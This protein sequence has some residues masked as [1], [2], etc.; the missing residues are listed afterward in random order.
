MKFPVAAIAA[1]LLLA[2]GVATAFPIAVGAVTV[3]LLGVMAFP[4]AILAAGAVWCYKRKGRGA[5]PLLAALTLVCSGVFLLQDFAQDQSSK[6]ALFTNADTSFLSPDIPFPFMEARDQAISSQAVSPAEFMEGLTAGHFKA[7]KISTYPSLFMQ[8]GQVS[9]SEIWRDKDVLIK[10]VNDLGGRVVLVDQYGGIAGSVAVAALKNFGLNIGFLQGGTTALSSLGWSMV[11]QGIAIGG[12]TVPVAEYRS[13]ISAHPDA[14]VIGVTT[15]DEF[16]KDG[17]IFGNRTLSLGDFISNYRELTLALMGKNVFVVGFETN[18]T[19]AT[20]IIVDLLVKA[21]VEVHYVMPNPDE[22]LV[23]PA[24]F[25]DYPN[26]SRTVTIEDAERYVLSRPDVEF[27]DFSEHAWP[28]GLH[29]LKDRYHR[30]PMEEVA[31]GRLPDFIASLDPQKVYIGLAFDRRTAYHSLLAGEYL[32]SRGAPWLGRFTL[33]SSLTESFL[34]IEEL[35]TD[36]EQFAYLIRNAGG[37]IGNAILGHGMALTL[38]LGALL[39]STA[40]FVRRSR[41]IGNTVLAS[42]VVGVWASVIQARNDYPQLEYSYWAFQG[43]CS[44]ALTLVC[45]I[46]WWRAQPKIRSFSQYTPELPPK[47]ALLNL[48]QKRGHRVLSGFVVKPQD[49]PSLLGIRL[50]A[51]QYIVRSAMARE[52]LD[53]ESTAGLYESYICPASEV[54]DKASQVFST[55]TQA[56]IDGFALVQPYCNAAW[57]GVIQL[58]SNDK[59]PMVICDI[60]SAE[61]V[62]SGEGATHSFEFPIWDMKVAPR[63]IRSAALALQDLV[64]VGAISIEFA[65]SRTGQLTI[66]QVNLQKSRACAAMRLSHAARKKVLEVECAHPDAISAAIVSAMAPGH[67]IAYG[68]RRFAVVVSPR[69]SRLT[70]TQDLK[71]L[72]FDPRLVKS[73]HLLAWVDQYSRSRE[74]TA[75]CEA[76]VA[77]VAAALSETAQSIGR[78]NRIA[79]YILA[80]GSN[81]QWTGYPRDFPSSQVGLLLANHQTPAWQGMA[82]LP[83]TGFSVTASEQE[84]S[85]EEWPSALIE[86]TSPIAWIKDATSILL[87]IRLAALLPTIKTICLAGKG[88]ELMHALGTQHGDWDELAA[89]VAASFVH[90]SLPL[91]SVCLNTTSINGVWRMPDAGITGKVITPADGLG[92]GI[93]LIDRCSMGYLP[94]LDGAIA[95]IANQGSITSHLMQHASAKGLPV[96][97]GAEVPAGIQAGDHVAITMQ[98]VI[99]RA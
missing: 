56:G 15:D 89:G 18:D 63:L 70:H 49:L 50:R 42:F 36:E 5:I 1:V 94:Y 91:G 76:S 81:E 59:C 62:T 16:V 48:A 26:D 32:S 60:G 95:V 8:T 55:F 25:D 13:W 67:I 40:F 92:Q 9:V 10:A 57:Y 12:S 73:H 33:A 28:I 41:Q 7:L 82:V 90:H 54:A 72:G 84:F 2:P 87:G 69:R 66:L 14:Y 4:V 24:Y 23:K 93:L 21:G 98:G 20:P 74:A 58:Q 61:A 30:L 27:L 6:V 79:T 29:F 3:G 53:H 11:D 86:A 47:A 17:W 88:G 31:K 38:L 68:R 99:S 52:A 65:L 19:G 39:G 71:A 78:M 43:A 75:T 77:S 51:G 64:E 97:I 34:T 44:V 85:K 80:T 46:V 45:I 83:L 37:F 96:V 35:N 22:I